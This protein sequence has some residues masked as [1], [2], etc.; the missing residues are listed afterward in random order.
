MPTYLFECLGCRLVVSQVRSVATRDD[1]MACPKCD[2]TMARR[3]DFGGVEFKG[4]GFYSTDKD[5]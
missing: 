1:R 3:L 4:K 5:K 2:L